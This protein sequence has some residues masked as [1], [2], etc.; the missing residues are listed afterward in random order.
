MRPGFHAPDLLVEILSP[1]TE[2]R[3]RGYKR[4]LYARFGER[5][6]WIADPKTQRIDVLGLQATGFV[7]LG[8]YGLTDHLNS[9]LFPHLQLGIA[10]VFSDE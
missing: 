3:D 2:I 4:A 8:T 7:S 5:E 1:S 6:Y 9:P 10:A